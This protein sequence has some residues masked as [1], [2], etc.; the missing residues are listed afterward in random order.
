MRHTAHWDGEPLRERRIEALQ[1]VSPR[2]VD[3]VEGFAES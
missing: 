1:K 2:E 3:L